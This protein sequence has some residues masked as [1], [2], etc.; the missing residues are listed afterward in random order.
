MF[1]KG[2]CYYFS[3][4]LFKRLSYLWMCKLSQ[5]ITV[6]WTL[7]PESQNFLNQGLAKP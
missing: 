7:K 1:Y 3:A 6:S 5:I 4:G 2:F